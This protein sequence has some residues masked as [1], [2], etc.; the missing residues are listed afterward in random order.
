[1]GLSDVWK[2][3]LGEIS[4]RPSGLPV[5]Q[6]KDK[7][8]GVTLDDKYRIHTI[9]DAGGMGYLYLAETA[10]SGDRVVVKLLPVEQLEGQKAHP[11]MTRFQRE[12]VGMSQF[13][14]PNI[15]SIIDYNLE[16]PSTPYIVMEYIDGYNL[17]EFMK[18][19]PNGL[20]LEAFYLLM[21][22][23]CMACSLIHS[24]SII[25]RDLKPH[26]MMLHIVNGEFEVKV[27]D[28]GLI[29]FEHVV[30]PDGKLNLTRKGEMIGTPVYMSPEQC[31]GRPITHLSD[32]YNLGL[33]AYEFLV[34]RPPF[35]GNNLEELVNLQV[36]E[37]AK[38]LAY[39]RPDIPARLV[40]AVEKAMD[41]VP[42]MR[43]GNCMGFWKAIYSTRAES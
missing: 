22:Q 26:N 42:S 35:E 18:Q 19:F 30:S 15:V 25:H 31:L 21:E 8:L 40:W 20:P 10:T 13:R 33:I 2:R 6:Q 12:A 32:I 1:M 23:I 11:F 17:K 28:F 9:L 37:P 38:P 5:V 29:M 14:H 41:K 16:H 3:E 43:F 34:G 7:F 27:L 24:K 36:N 4:S 39:L